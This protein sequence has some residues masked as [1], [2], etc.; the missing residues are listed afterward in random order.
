MVEWWELILLSVVQGIAEFLPISSSGHLVVLEHWLEI[1]SDV[2]DIN[3]I[4]HAGT[5]LA[6][7]LVYRERILHMLL[8]DRRLLVLVVVGTLPA[9]GFGLGIKLLFEST[10]ES[11]LV[12]G[13]CLPLTGLLLFWCD[14]STE[15]ELTSGQLSWK[16]SLGI[17]CAQAIAVLPGISR[18][19]S[20]IAA[21][22]AT[23]LSRSEAATFSFLLAIPALSGAAILEI[24]S[25]L[26]VEN[27][28]ETPAQM[29]LAGAILSA[30]VGW[31]SLHGLLKILQKGRLRIFGIWCLILGGFVLYQASL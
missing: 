31:M 2:S 10:L 5:L 17:G 30:F 13:I 27:S 25:S 7:L 23:G 18:S 26:S 16:Q 20:T 22:L 1:E 6:I 28:L 24:L 4:L 3:I 19:G 8:S 14:R 29:L 21:G 12:A 11:S 15:G 9:V